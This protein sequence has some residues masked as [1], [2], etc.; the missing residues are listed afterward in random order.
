MKTLIIKL[1]AAG[2]VLRTT[3]LLNVV[4][5]E[6]FWL[7]SSD[8]AILLE[9]NDRI[10]QCASWATKAILATHEY[11]LVIN[12]EDSADVGGFLRTLKF[13]RLF[14]AYLD[15]SNHL[16]YTESSRQWFDLSLI[17]RFGREMADELKLK[18]RLSYQDIL[19]RSL[20]HE[21]KDEQYFLPRTIPSDL[22]GDIAISEKAGSVWPMKNWAYYSELR[23]KLQKA[24]YKVNV[25]PQRATLLEHVADVQNHKLL[26]SGD[27]L[28]MHIALG[29]GVKCITI[30]Q[31]T[32]P[33]EIHGYG[34]QTKIISPLLQKYFYKRH[35]DRAATTCI[36]LDDVYAA[37]VNTYGP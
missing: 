3:P 35:F 24:G 26:L 22:R 29:S 25:L 18:N 37:V 15:E 32:S 5:G 12:L 9:D 21:F 31:C 36:S 2:D 8:N 16:Q 7:T 27:S 10:K 1:G 33:W 6:I 11:D 34:L 30:F 19:F 14:G 28:P 4:S 13:K 20:G 17:S 23:A